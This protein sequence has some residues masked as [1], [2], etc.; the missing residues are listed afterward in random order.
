M[1]NFK[2]NFPLNEPCHGEY[3]TEAELDAMTVEELEA[4]LAMA[5]DSMAEV[6]Y[7]GDVISRYLD[8][9]DRKDPIPERPD[10]E[11]SY[12]R[13]QQK[14]QAMC[15][16]VPLQAKRHYPIRRLSRVLI[17]AVLSIVISF[18][19]LFTAQALGADVFGAMAQWSDD[20]FSFGNFSAQNAEDKF[21]S[22]EQQVPITDIVGSVDTINEDG[23]DSAKYDSLQDALNAYGFTKNTLAP[24]WIPDGYTLRSVQVSFDG[25]SQLKFESIYEKSKDQLLCTLIFWDNPS[26]SS[27]YSKDTTSVKIYKVGNINHFVLSNNDACVAVW[28]NE[29]FEGNITGH[30]ST[31]DMYRMLD[32]IYGGNTL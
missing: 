31:Q 29:Q 24:N 18:G 11:A 17:V 27:V 8:A 1:S 10:A 3:L 14:M 4:A 20:F 25:D 16:N 19:C 5:L 32:S 23:I 2:Q 9:L 21:P 7:D 6:T 22:S 28:Q 30:I 13:F 26:L 15:P 12:H